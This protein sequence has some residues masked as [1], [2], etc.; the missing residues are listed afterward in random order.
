MGVIIQSFKI[1]PSSPPPD[2]QRFDYWCQIWNHSVAFLKILTTYLFDIYLICIS[3]VIW[4]FSDFL[5]TRHV[6]AYSQCCV[7]IYYNPYCFK[8]SQ[9]DVQ[10]VRNV[11]PTAVAYNIWSITNLKNCEKNIIFKFTLY[12]FYKYLLE[13]DL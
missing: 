12:H 1:G 8:R 6:C 4:S 10:Y 9:K 2:L 5:D 7:K 13:N 3:R 11:W